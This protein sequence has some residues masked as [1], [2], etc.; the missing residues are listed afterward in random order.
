MQATDA[1]MHEH[2]LIERVSR[3]LVAFADGQ[4]RNAG[5]DRAELKRF[6]TFIGRFS[7]GTHHRKEEDIL[8]AEMVEGGFSRDGG[9]VAVMLREHDEVRSYGAVLVDLAGR[10]RPWSAAD[11]D[12]L[13]Q[14][15]S[16]YVELLLEHIQKED[17]IL[18]PVADA[19]LPAE[20]KARVDSRCARF[21]AES[22]AETQ[23]LRI[24]GEELAARHGGAQR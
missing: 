8:F 7:D 21:D 14:A 9:P 4:R 12:R 2:R 20:S 6:V 18:Y 22:S 1:L 3:A 11:R 10:E 24:L 23:S 5:D 19:H 13:A 15:A 16:A 17:G